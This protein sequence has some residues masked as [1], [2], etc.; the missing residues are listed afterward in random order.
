[1]YRWCAPRRMRSVGC[2]IGMFNSK[3]IAICKEANDHLPAPL[4]GRVGR[5]GFVLVIAL[6]LLACSGLEADSNNPASEPP[7]PF[8]RTPAPT[9][10]PSPTPTPTLTSTPTPSPTPGPGLDELMGTPNALAAAGELDAALVAYAALAQLYPSR[11]EPL[12]GQAAIAQRMGEWT[13]SLTYLRAAVDADP[14]SLEALRQLALL[15]ETL[16]RYADVVDVYGQMLD[17]QPDNPDLLV[18][19]AM[20]YARL[21][22]TVASIGDLQA[23][24]AI[25]PYRDYAWLNVAAA[26]YGARA[27]D[28][29]IEIASA[30]LEASPR[31][32]SLWL[33]RGLAY[34]SLGDTDSALSDFDATIALDENNYTAYHWRGLTLVELERYDDAISDLQQA[35][36][37]GVLSGVTGTD[38]AYEAMGDVAD[39]MALNGDVQ[40]AFSY[41]AGQVVQHGS[42]DALLLGYA[43]IDWRRGNLVLSTRRL[44]SLVD[45]GYIPAL[46][47]RALIYAE[48]DESNAAIADL[49]AYLAM[50]HFGPQVESARAL[51]E[52][53][54]VDPNTVSP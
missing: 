51:L 7:S 41:L 35:A 19:R 20:A 11:S 46:Y 18:A 53:L 8:T 38:E 2:A 26:A 4:P 14:T 52:S 43:R 32:A 48:Q 17:L 6:W 21:G 13:A 12:L 50:R 3:W 45:A 42:R 44:D 10:T 34:L 36:D 28:V 5:L 23:A 33:T 15:L 30:G 22:E 24:Q 54:G 37:L 16:E 40:A 27:Y 1:M 25:D 9:S 31:S 29:A 39:A 49:R 47:W